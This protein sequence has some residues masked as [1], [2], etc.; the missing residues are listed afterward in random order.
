M[1]TLS[2]VN[3]STVEPLFYFVTTLF[4]L[5]IIMKVFVLRGIKVDLLGLKF[6]DTSL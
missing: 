6:F 2:V 1:Y 5:V 4:L 3:V